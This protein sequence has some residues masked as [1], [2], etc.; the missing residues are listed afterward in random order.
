MPP[1]GKKKEFD[2]QFEAFLKE[3]F[4]SDDGSLDSAKVSKH[5]APKEQTTPK[6][7]SK[8]WWMQ[9]DDDDDDDDMGA[10]FGS[11]KTS[12]GKSF[13]KKKKPAEPKHSTPKQTPLT[14]VEPSTPELT[15]EEK[16]GRQKA[17]T[18]KK[19]RTHLKTKQRGVRGRGDTGTSM[20]KDSL[21]DISEKSEEDSNKDRQAAA[22]GKE[23]SFGS[24]KTSRPGLETLDEIRDK[25][26]FFRDLEKNADGTL[27][28]RR[29][30]QD[31]SQS[32]TT[33]SPEGAAKTAATLA[34]LEDIEEDMPLTTPSNRPFDPQQ[35]DEQITQD[36]SQKPSMLSKVSLMDSMESTM[37]TTGSPMVG[38][39]GMHEKGDRGD[40]GINDEMDGP[41]GQHSGHHTGFMG[42]TTSHEIEA[43]HKALREVGLSPTIY[44]DSQPF[45]LSSQGNRSTTEMMQKLLSGE[46]GKQRN[47]EE[48]L[49]EVERLEKKS[50]ENQLE[51][52][53]VELLSDRRRSPYSPKSPRSLERQRRIDNDEG[54]G[55][56]GHDY[57][58]VPDSARG[59]DHSHTDDTERYNPV[60]QVPESKS[61]PKSIME[62]GRQKKKKMKPEKLEKGKDKP[63]KQV[64]PRRRPSPRSSLKGSQSR[65]PSAS[66]RRWMSPRSLSKD[67][68]RSRSLSPSKT[69]LKFSHVK[70]SGYG[71]KSPPKGNGGRPHSARD[72]Y[73]AEEDY[74]DPVPEEEGNTNQNA[75]VRK[76]TK[77]DKSKSGKSKHQSARKQQA[78]TWSPAEVTKQKIK[79]SDSPMFS[80]ER[81]GH[82][83][84]ETQ[85]KASV[86]SFAHYIKDHF[87]ESDLP[88]AKYSQDEPSLAASWRGDKTTDQMPS[89]LV[90]TDQDWQ[91]LYEEAKT[92]NTK[93]KADKLAMEKEY[94]RMLESQKLEFE[95]QIFKLKQEVYVLSAK[96][97]DSQS[98]IQ[99]R[100]ADRNG[101]VSPDQM[102]KLDREIQE[103]EKLIAGYQ[104]ENKRLYEQLKVQQKQVKAT[105]DRMF[106]ENQKMAT[107]ITNL[108]TKLE[109]KEDEARCKGIITSLPAQQKIA[110]GD[111]SSA[112][113]AGRIAQLTVELK[114]AKRLQDNSNRELEVLQRSKIELEQHIDKLIKER[115]S[116]RQQVA[117][118][119]SLKSEEARVIEDK[120]KSENERLTRKLKWYAENQ[121]LLDSD[122][123]HLKNQEEEIAKHKLRIEHLTS[124]TGRRL[125]DN[126][127][128][129][130]E[131][132]NDAKRIQDL[133]RQVKEMEGIIRRR[134][135]NSLPALIMTAAVAPDEHQPATKT[136]TMGVLENR[137]KKL[138]LELEGKD[139]EAEKMLR[140]VEQK[141]LSI[142]NQYEE[143]I[144]DLETQLAI[145]VRPEDNAL[146][147]YQHPHTHA[148]ALQRELESVRERYKAKNTELTEEVSRLNTEIA[149]LSKGQE[150]TLKNEQSF[151]KNKE[152]EYKTQIHKLQQ[153]LDSKSHDLGVAVK[154]VERLRKEKN[155][156]VTG[157]SG[158][159]DK[160]KK[161]NQAWEEEEALSLTDRVNRDRQYQP[162]SFADSQITETLQENEY[163]RSKIE[164]LQLAYDE[165]RLELRKLQAESEAMAR[166][167]REN[168]ED[169][170]DVLRS[171]HQKEFRKLLADQALNHST[172]R[173][174]ELQ[175][176][177]DA[178]EV[179][180]HHLKERLTKAELDSEQVS[181]LK[182]REA[183]LKTHVEKLQECLKEAKLCQTPEM[184]HFDSIKEKIGN[185][186]Q[187]HEQREK[188][189][190][191]VIRNAKQ[192]A[193]VQLEH[194][195]QKWR[196]IV[197]SKNKEIQKF[198]TELDAILEVLR[199]LQRQGVVIPISASGS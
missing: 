15:P 107:E 134:H 5:L 149:K 37:N 175:S 159:K 113:G 165:Q 29:L 196:K 12:S 136:P 19:E 6:S 95:D 138:E 70:S 163:L 141:Y 174:A 190:Q 193:S 52:L 167:S 21:E 171:S 111:T 40:Q 4:S 1:K 147:D 81:K 94:D 71:Q 158:P 119:K 18:G 139:T 56:R 27:D 104:Q 143:R 164:Q 11:G 122:A 87:A 51:D 28:F 114:E 140:S 42:T 177:V 179:L 92:H 3:S 124:E 101:E 78:Q 123:K 126:K 39:S 48:I 106:T 13:L 128:R 185:M 198:R 54:T 189:L 152:T 118:S 144:R 97:P 162:N 82:N 148:V 33:M 17:R 26:S 192:V 47:V 98:E 155:L 45:D 66:P 151:S 62:R 53:D 64:S 133:Q 115:E 65:S 93:L 88:Q 127:V 59:F 102:E 195:V 25:E 173:M 154:T 86:D 197:E 169:R 121:K 112:L 30:N 90:G 135:P 161:S 32:A 69:G 63:P 74:Q 14:P 8:P 68:P 41:G 183:G 79:G 73:P 35:S 72:P 85:L 170:I 7:K 184:K 20:S 76:E 150:A 182:I 125:E 44:N 31:L 172:S 110:K 55:T 120:F 50:K 105:E 132:A 187:R 142:K 168:F 10:N 156:P 91:R 145:Y 100:L 131:R 186:E 191:E 23:S 2:R 58:P 96:L 34:A 109:R 43:L 89:L 80:K 160:N 194:A 146:K 108:R 67:D 9:S 166:K 129:A 24:E 188:E 99:K 36:P 181:I 199:V 116:L 137:I 49:K 153:D 60:T 75:P 180:V 84:M 176:K 157:S 38:R 22:A 130:K 57:S 16:Q 77:K 83:V 46:P 178:Q 103:Q 61:T 117:E